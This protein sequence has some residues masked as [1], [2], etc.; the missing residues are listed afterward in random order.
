MA[1]TPMLRRARAAKRVLFLTHHFPTPE[2]P[3]AARPWTEATLLRELG[4]RVTVLT[5]GTHYLTGAS[6]R[7]ARGGL[8]S[9]EERDGIRIV[10]TYAPAG[11][12]TS[13]RRRALN[14][15][16]YSALAFA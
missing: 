11:H 5:A 4:L 9:T 7:G 1:A 14:Y 6:T 16:T 2:E 8:W 12:R 13:M 3:G 15:V 10:K